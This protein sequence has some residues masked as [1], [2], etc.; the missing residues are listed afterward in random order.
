MTP[1]YF[2]FVKSMREVAPGAY[3][4]TSVLPYNDNVAI[5]VQYPCNGTYKSV[6]HIVTLNAMQFSAK[7][8]MP[9]IYDKLLAKVKQA[10]KQEADD[11][12]DKD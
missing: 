10:L 7:D 2:S 5:T 9:L 3:I 1:E 11:D 6:S 4:D 8:P 12:T